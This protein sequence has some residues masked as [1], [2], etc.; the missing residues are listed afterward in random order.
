LVGKDYEQALD[1]KL[2]THHHEHLVIIPFVSLL[3]IGAQDAVSGL[4]FEGVRRKLNPRKDAAQ[5]EP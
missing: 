1:I 3:G 4:V 2:R 5:V